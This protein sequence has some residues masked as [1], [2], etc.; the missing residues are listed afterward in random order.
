MDQDAW[1]SCAK[2][3]Q[4]PGLSRR[5]RGLAFSMLKLPKT[6]AGR[7]LRKITALLMAYCFFATSAWS[8]NSPGQALYRGT[9]GTTWQVLRNPLVDV[10]AAARNFTAAA[11]NN[12][13]RMPVSKILTNLRDLHASM[14]GVQA[15][16]VSSS[17][18]SN[19]N[20]TAIPAGDIIWFTAVLKLNGTVPASP[21]SIGVQN[22]TIRFTA[23]STNYS[24]NPPGAVITFSPSVTTTTASFDTANNPQS[25]WLQ[26]Q[27][28]PQPSGNTLLQAFAYTVPA[29]GLP[30]G[31]KNVTWSNTFSSDTAN[32]SLNWQ[33]A[34]A[35]YT[36]CVNTT[37]SSDDVKPT[38][39]NTASIY[40]N[41]DHAGTPEACKSSVT[42]GATG[43][44][45]SNYTGSLS[46]TASVT[47][48]V[49]S[50]SPVITAT[51]NP[52]PNGNGW[53]KTNVTVSFVCSDANFAIASCPAPVTVSSEGPGQVITG[54]VVDQAG[55]SATAQASVTVNLDKTSPSIVA[56]ATSSAGS[57][58]N[59]LTLP[60][61]ITFTCV[62]AVSGVASCPAPIQVTTAGA[63]QVYSGTATDQAGNTA[64]T[65]IAVNTESS[66][67][68]ITAGFSPPP[69]NGWNNTSVAVTY[70]CTGGV[71]PVHCP[72]SQTL[73]T[74]GAGQVVSAT[75]LDAAGQS[76]TFTA[77]LNIDET[78]PT[79]NATTTPAANAA[80][81]NT[82]D[83]TISYLCSDALSGVVFC[84]PPRG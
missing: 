50:A 43:G 65:S 22:S 75:A 77:T 47:P 36:G 24:L 19:F 69:V 67:L 62:D 73:S 25:V 27:K 68:A 28:N 16:G 11:G 52:S 35:V 79:I 38:D 59:V 54:T 31:I 76:S 20:A 26:N 2:S 40:K 41:S 14:A 53:N 39:D 48:P 55:G 64:S 74:Q 30:G 23:G 56:S 37:Y 46:G 84:P 33:W 49:A 4:S 60:V 63:N 6:V 82:S 45:A 18:S 10:K 12:N 7:I 58:G 29:G 21:A 9:R 66:P 57:G 83:V 42:Q 13:H 78:L 61:T 5:T 34:A 80:G 72:Q 71:P 70:Q 15:G 1:H 17:I 51:I 44:G 8:L 81:W 32:I 3:P